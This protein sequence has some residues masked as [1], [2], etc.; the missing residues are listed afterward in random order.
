MRV[1]VRN[2]TRFVRFALL[3]LLPMMLPAADLTID[4]VTVAGK[5]LKAMQATLAALGIPTEYGGPHSNHAT[6]MALTSFPDGSYLELIAIQPNADPA[7]VAAHYWSK[8]MQNDAGP[9][10]WAVRPKDLAAEVQRLQASGVVVTSPAR[11]GRARP[12][13]V[14]LDWETANVGKEPNGTFFPFLIRDFTPR[15]QRAYPGGK[16]TTQDFSGVARVVIAVRDLAASVKRYRDAYALPEP[17]Q[18]DD[19]RFGARLASFLGTP[20]VLATP[21]SAQSWLAARLDKIGEGPCAFV[22]HRKNSAQNAKP[23]RLASQATWFGLDISWLD[24]GKTGW[25]LGFE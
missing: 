7:A 22:L 21:A 4:H 1:I 14:R 11:A 13:G 16:P 17:V 25:W 15:Q 9:S 6:E 18:Q 19:T 8:H 3:M 24:T 10:A 12:D 23:Y 2:Y 20:I 5:D